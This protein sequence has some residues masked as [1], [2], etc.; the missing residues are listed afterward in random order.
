MA[1]AGAACDRGPKIGAPNQMSRRNDAQTAEAGSPVPNAP[2]VV[3]VDA[4][5]RGV[6]GVTVNFL[7]T[8]GGGT[9]QNLTATTDKT[10]TASAGIW[11]QIGRAHV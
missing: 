10:G 3:I 11:T 1:T 4:N 6:P 8:S 5:A 7:V 9:V 2:E